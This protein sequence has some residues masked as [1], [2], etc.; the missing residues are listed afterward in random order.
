MDTKGSVTF[1]SNILELY[2]LT[3]F[4]VKDIITNW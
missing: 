1:F 2:L 4:Y 3:I